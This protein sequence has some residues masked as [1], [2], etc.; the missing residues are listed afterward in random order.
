MPESRQDDYRRRRDRRASPAARL[1]SVSISRARRADGRACTRRNNAP[2]ARA[3][4]AFGRT[5]MWTCSRFLSGSA[6]S[7]F[8][9]PSSNTAGITRSRAEAVEAMIVPLL[10]RPYGRDRSLVNAEFSCPD[11]LWPLR[12]APNSVEPFRL[13]T[14]VPVRRSEPRVSMAPTRGRGNRGR[15]NQAI[16]LDW[17]PPSSLVIG[18]WSFV[19]QGWILVPSTF[20]NLASQAGCAGQAGAVTRLPSTWAWSMPMSMYFPPARVTSGPT[21]G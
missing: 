14:L 19:G 1:I 18:N 20:K 10:G 11:R 8:R 5:A 16:R 21:A 4:L 7:G 17:V 13:K 6:C 3:Q 9:T 12:Q 2:N 15:R